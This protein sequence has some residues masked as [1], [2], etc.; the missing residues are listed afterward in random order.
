MHTRKK[1]SKVDLL[2]NHLNTQPKGTLNISFHWTGLKWCKPMS[3]TCHAVKHGQTT[4]KWHAKYFTTK[5]TRS[6]ATDS[7]NRTL[8]WYASTSLQLVMVLHAAP[9]WMILGTTCFPWSDCAYIWWVGGWWTDPW[10]NM[11]LGSLWLGI[12]WYC[13]PAELAPCP[14]LVSYVLILV[15]LAKRKLLFCLS[16]CCP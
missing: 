12:L 13:H 16:K 9:A 11:Q 7:S 15:I 3:S 6:T 8:M 4:V 5:K 14:S 10:Q 2:K 1:Q